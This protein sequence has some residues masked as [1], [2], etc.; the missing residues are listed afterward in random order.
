M[1]GQDSLRLMDGRISSVGRV[2]H[3]TLHVRAGTGHVWSLTGPMR[4]PLPW[5]ET[6]WASSSGKQGSGLPTSSRA[7]VPREVVLLSRKELNSWCNHL[8]FF[9]RPSMTSVQLLLHKLHLF[10][11]F[12]TSFAL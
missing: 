12:A 11:Y 9:T 10:K 3:T 4:A 2:D 6:H 8:W 7:S 1:D 5:L